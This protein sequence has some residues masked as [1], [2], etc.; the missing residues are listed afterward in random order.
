MTS[1]PA[2]DLYRSFL[3]VLDEGSLSAAARALGLTQP[4]I[5]RHMSELEEALGTP[6]FTRSQTGLVAT[7]S[8]LSLVPHAQAMAAAADALVRAA[9]G[10]IDEAKGSV[11]V[12][13]S[14]FV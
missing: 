5:G 9:S 11:R 8:A 1:A 3:A 2:W 7:Q 14:E 12:T 4:T 10:E 6:L 13:A